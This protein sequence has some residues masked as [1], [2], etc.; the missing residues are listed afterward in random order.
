MTR[1]YKGMYQMTKSETTVIVAIAMVVVVS[2]SFWGAH[3]LERQAN[4]GAN[5]SVAVAQ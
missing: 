3:V 2:Y 5:S 1:V 4:A